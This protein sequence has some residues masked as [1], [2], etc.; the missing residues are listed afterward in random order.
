MQEIHVTLEALRFGGAMVYPLLLLAVLAV[1]VILDKAFVYWRFVRLPGPV[2]ELVETY[3]FAWADLERQLTGLDRRNYFQRFFR[4]VMDNRQRPVWWVESRAGDE[5]QLIERELSRGLWM[6]ETTVTAAPLLGLLGTITGMMHA[7]NLIG[8]NGLVDPTGVTAGVA[9][10]LIAT[11]L[12]LFIAVIALFAFNFFSRR[13]SQVLDE[14]ERLGTRLVDHIRM[15]ED[16][17]ESAHEA[18]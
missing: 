9:Q 6:L 8:N 12:G 17:Q 5:A 10:A 7:F 4:E 18:A 15:S 11:A 13:Q 1:V 3:D 16:F 2:L 14:M